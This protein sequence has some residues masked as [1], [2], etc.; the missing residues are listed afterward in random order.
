MQSHQE[1]ESCPV[2]SPVRRDAVHWGRHMNGG[3]S[4]M[5]AAINILFVLLALAA[6][7]FV[8]VVPLYNYLARP[9]RAPRDAAIILFSFIFTV[10]ILLILWSI[11]GDFV[12]RG[13]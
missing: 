7:Y 3:M 5:T 13:T 1:R 8:F 2:I 9:Q 11:R 4:E 12:P 6:C 10:V